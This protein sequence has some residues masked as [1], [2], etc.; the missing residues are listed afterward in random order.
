M[1]T[2][3]A[4]KSVSLSQHQLAGRP[5]AFVSLL[6]CLEGERVSTQVC[7]SGTPQAATDLQQLLGGGWNMSKALS[8]SRLLYLPFFFFF[9]FF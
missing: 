5:R 7:T 8:S 6:G 3:V 1:P 9:F 2:A 4:G